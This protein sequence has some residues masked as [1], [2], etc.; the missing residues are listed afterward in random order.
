MAPPVA[1]RDRKAGAEIYRLR[2]GHNA[3]IAQI[4]GAVAR[5]NVHATA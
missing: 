1:I 3:D 5:R 4:T 2:L